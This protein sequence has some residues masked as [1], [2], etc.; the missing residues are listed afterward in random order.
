MLAIKSFV[1]KVVPARRSLALS[2]LASR[3]A[4]GFHGRH[5]PNSYEVKALLIPG[6]L[7]SY[8]PDSWRTFAEV[9]GMNAEYMSAQ[10]VMSHVQ[11]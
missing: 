6:L 11:V 1:A 5:L 3:L 10:S 7:P 9:A 8:T 2:N 4:L